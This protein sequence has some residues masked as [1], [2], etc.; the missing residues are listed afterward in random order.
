M[1]II[2]KLYIYNLYNVT[3]LYEYE[4]IKLIHII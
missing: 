4:Y 3:K 1:Y 2:Y